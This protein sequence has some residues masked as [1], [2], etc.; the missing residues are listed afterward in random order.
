MSDDTTILT[1]RLRIEPFTERHL[2]ERYVGWLND[3]GTM[4]FSENRFRRHTLQSCREYVASFAGSP[5]FLWAVVATDESFGH[6]GNMN[7]YV[8]DRH[9]LA[10]VGILIGERSCAGRG[11]ATEAWVGVCDYLLRVKAFRKVTAGA[12]AVNTPMLRVMER[13][14]MADDGRRVRQHVWEDQD[15]DVVHGALFRDDW[16]ARYPSGPF[17]PSS[18]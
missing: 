15:V 16:I 5:N 10:D 18:T 14:G 3:A 2:T 6:I 13:A 12:L 11:Y 8:D 17:G 1:P 7:A 4:R 9:G